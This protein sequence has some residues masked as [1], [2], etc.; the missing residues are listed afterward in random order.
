MVPVAESNAD[1][2]AGASNNGQD[3][4]LIASVV[5]SA[6]GSTVTW[7]VEL[8]APKITV[9]LGGTKVAAPVCV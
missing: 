9:P 7:A 6:D 5:A 4:R 3:H 2:V 1:L 8:P